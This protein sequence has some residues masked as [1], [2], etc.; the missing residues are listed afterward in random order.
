FNEIKTI[1]DAYGNPIL[2]KPIAQF[3]HADG[4][5]GAHPVPIG[6]FGVSY[7]MGDDTGLFHSLV[8]SNLT[9]GRTYYYA[10]VS[11]DKGYA[12]DFFS[13]GLTQFE[14]LAPTSPTESS[15]IIQ[16]DPL[17]RPTFIDRNAAVMV[18]VEPAA[19][20]VEP[21]L[22]EGVERVSGDATGNIRIDL[23]H[24]DEL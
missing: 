14:N 7:D 3:D 23:L 11:V 13:R 22:Q 8:D 20:Y 6:D 1:S 24:P 5:V 15:K 21:S 2:W 18:P 4:L 9:N 10:V 17:G 16:V 19:G 12:V